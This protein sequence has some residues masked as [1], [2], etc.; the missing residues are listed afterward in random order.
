VTST[1]TGRDEGFAP[2]V[3]AC[4]R[5][6]ILGSMPSVKSLQQQQY[7]GNSQNSFWRLMGEMFAAGPELAYAERVAVLTAAN[8]AVWDVVAAARRPGSL[9]SAI[10]MASV[11]VNDFAAF[12]QNNAGITHVFFNGQKAA[13]IYRQRA[14]SAVAAVAPSLVYT[15]LPS[16]SPAMATL[17]F[18]GKLDA[19]RAVGEAGGRR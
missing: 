16:T 4:P 8:V 10:D 11:A 12:T 2:L 6:L 3:G 14:L 9:D 13:S 15:T 18:V 1:F 7:Y 19:W 5:V 17:D